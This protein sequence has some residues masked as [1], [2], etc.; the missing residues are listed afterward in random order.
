M[1]RDC[2]STFPTLVA[3]GKARVYAHHSVYINPKALFYSYQGICR[4]VAMFNNVHEAY[5]QYFMKPLTGI[6]CTAEE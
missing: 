6:F 4:P 3:I 5:L 2:K 1:N